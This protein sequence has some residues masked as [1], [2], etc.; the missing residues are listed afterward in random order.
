MNMPPRIMISMMIMISLIS[1][2]N[3]IGEYRCLL[4]AKLEI[5]LGGGYS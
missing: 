5:Y 3:M 2:I 4:I 1:L